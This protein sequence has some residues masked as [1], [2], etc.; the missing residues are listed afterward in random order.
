MTLKELC[1]EISCRNSEKNSKDPFGS[2]P[3]SE[4]APKIGRKDSLTFRIMTPESVSSVPEIKTYPLKQSDPLF[5]L[6]WVF[7]GD[8]FLDAAIKP[9]VPPFCC[10]LP[11]PKSGRTQLHTHDY[12][13][14]AY[15]VSGE[16]SQKILGKTITFR[17]GELCL[18]DKNCL[19]QDIMDTS[20]AVIL[21][22]GIANATFDDIMDCPLTEKR[23]TAFLNSALLKQ[24][25]LLQYLHFRPHDG[26]KESMESHLS[27][28]LLELIRHDEAAPYICRGLLIRI[29]RMLSTQYD[30]SLSREL[31]KKMNWILFEEITSYIKAHARDITIQELSEHFHFQ[32]D[33]FNRLIKSKT[34]LTYTGYLQG[35][36]LKQAEELLLCTRRS[37]EEIAEEVGYQ[38]KGYFYKIFTEKYH[39]T[40]AQ[41]R[42]KGL[43]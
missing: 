39:I 38:N 9:A 24:K 7:H 30:F 6:C 2:V 32:E 27:Q 4:G 25:N 29:F 12:L 21:F 22:L 31:R 20:P 10:R 37:I 8:G 13:E 35:I 41:Y 34:G 17:E 1:E 26:A 36:R 11:F 16:F 15:I 18:I 42:K 14:L 40:P 3:S 5:A 43:H 28:L 19:H 33:Y 23:I